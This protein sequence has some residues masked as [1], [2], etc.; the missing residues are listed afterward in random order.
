MKNTIAQRILDFLKGFPPFNALN[1]EQLFAIASEVK[2]LYLEKDTFVFQEN[3]TLHDSFYVVKDGAI[4][5][6]KGEKLVD[7][8]DE[9]DIFG[10]RAL[11]RKDHYL[12]DA[13]AIEESIVYSIS[14]KLL[15]EIINNN[16]KANQFLI[17]SF[18]TNTRNPYN[19]EGRGTLYA[20][21]AILQPEASSFTEVQSANY[22]KNPVVCNP[23]ITIKE[24]SLIMSQNKVGSI[25]ITK[26][27]LPIG[28]ITDKDL[29]NKI[30]TG[31]HA[32]TENVKAIMSSP[33]ITFPEDISVAEAQI[34]MLKNDISHLCIT[35]D[36]TTNSELIG[37]LSEHDIIVING[38]NPSVL[39]KE[40][41]RANSAESLKYIREKAQE[42][43]KGYLKKNMPISFISKIIS[44]I[45]DAITKRI[46]DLSITEIGKE[47]PVSFAWLAIG[48]QGRKEQL[49]FTDQDNALVYEDVIEESKTKAYF[50]KLATLVNDKLAIVGFKLCP[51][52]MMASNTKWC[53]SV[54]DW[55]S[56]FTN[57]ITQPDEEKIQLCN[58]FFDYN[59]VYG[60]QKL[61]NQLSESIYK[62]IDNHKIF[63]NFMGR[64]ALKSPPPLSFFR[65]FLVEDSGEHK[66]QFDIKFRAIIPLVDAARVLILSHNVKDFNSTIARYQKLIELEPQNKDIFESCIYAFRLLLRFRTKQGLKHNDSGQFIDVKNLSKSKKLKLKGCF[67]PIKDVQELLNAR[68]KLSQL[69]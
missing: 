15:E 63:L 38:N 17:A 4:G 32:I 48:S 42:L 19:I 44:A 64:N 12:L 10:L 46:I 51:K 6:F 52:N 8:C 49:L 36:G 53:L 61:V 68:F 57:W 56:Q 1:H 7:K 24:A 22:S 39:L 18:A 69:L 54:S 55:N 30:A 41:K 13:K 62:A 27:K 43:L 37:I 60:N 28:I 23:E 26:N 47:P 2:V 35:K 9:G 40:I 31:L 65:H 59:F 34:A 14:A 33:V 21:E 3:D 66:Y 58:I 20:T 16:P 67:K 50:L 11:I 25:I 45:N 29:R 5:V